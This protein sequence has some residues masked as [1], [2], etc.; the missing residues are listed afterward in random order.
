MQKQNTIQTVASQNS[1]IGEQSSLTL[2]LKHGGSETAIILSVSI[3]LLT[4]AEIIKVLVP[5]MLQR[6]ERK[7]GQ[8]KK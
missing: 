7:T 2:L 5:I 6:T 3:L 1:P 4:V 8:R